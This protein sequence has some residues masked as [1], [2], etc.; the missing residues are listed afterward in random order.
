[1]VSPP[2]PCPPPLPPFLYGSVSTQENSKKYFVPRKVLHVE[3]SFTG[4]IINPT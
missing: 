4:F 1:M 3:N 2:A